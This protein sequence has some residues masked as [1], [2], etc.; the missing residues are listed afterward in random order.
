MHNVHLDAYQIG[1]Y[2]VTVEEDPR[3]VDDDGYQDERWWRAGG[4]AADTDPE[5]GTS[6][7]SIP[8]G[9]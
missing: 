8:T 3:F 7:S 2:P 4:F 1:R 6:R 5:T 9:R